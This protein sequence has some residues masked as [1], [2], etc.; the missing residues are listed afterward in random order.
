MS[1]QDRQGVRTPQDVERKYLLSL[2]GLEKAVKNNED[3]LNK[4]QK[5][6]EEFV[7]STLGS[8]EELQSQ[9]DGNITTWFYSG[10]PTLSNLPA[11]EW[12]TDNQK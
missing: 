5:S 9:I 4:T 12:T 2:V 8:I 10:V 6:L 7:T 3:G 1:K 11:S